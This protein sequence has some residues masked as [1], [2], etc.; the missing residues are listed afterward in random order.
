MFLDQLEPILSSS[1]LV[2]QF[3]NFSSPRVIH[4]KRLD[5]S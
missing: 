5:G 3:W 4:Y 2:K 1:F